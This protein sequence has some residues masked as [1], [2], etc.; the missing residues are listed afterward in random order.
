[1]S[2]FTFKPL[3]ISI[4]PCIRSIS[5]RKWENHKRQL[6][7]NSPIPVEQIRPQRTRHGVLPP[8]WQSILNNPLLS[9]ST[10]ISPPT[11]IGFGF[12]HP[13]QSYPSRSHGRLIASDCLF[14]FAPLLHIDEVTT[15]LA[16]LHPPFTHTLSTECLTILFIISPILSAY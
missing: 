14:L 7:H 3:M 12:W 8:R 5:N 10:H 1:M 9:V 6:L 2:F 15:L 13:A 4:S 11:H 16:S